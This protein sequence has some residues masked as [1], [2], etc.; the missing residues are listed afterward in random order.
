LA[1]Q[2]IIETSVGSGP[3]D[4]VFGLRGG[5]RYEDNRGGRDYKKDTLHTPV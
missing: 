2:R 4:R 3:V 5:V 1:I